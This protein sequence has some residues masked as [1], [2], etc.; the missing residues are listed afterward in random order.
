[1]SVA[2]LCEPDDVPALR[3]LLDKADHAGADVDVQ[4]RETVDLRL[5]SAPG[6]EVWVGAVASLIRSAAHRQRISTPRNR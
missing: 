1:M 5:R 2:D 3:S 6:A 4:H